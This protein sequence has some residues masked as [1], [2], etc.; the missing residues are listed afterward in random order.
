MLFAGVTIKYGLLT[1]LLTVVIAAE[2]VVIV[3]Y[4]ILCAENYNWWWTSFM[5]M[6]SVGIYFLAFSLYYLHVLLPGESVSTM[7]YTAYYLLIVAIIVMVMMGAVGF[8]TAFSFID[9]LFGRS[10]LD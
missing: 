4:V 1:V 8:V 2:V 9:I 10:K 5:S 3:M 7:L 6:G